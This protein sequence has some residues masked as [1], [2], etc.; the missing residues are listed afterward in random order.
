MLYQILKFPAKLSLHLYIRQLKINDKKWLCTKGTLLLA[1]NH[2]NSF[3]VAIIYCSLFN[4]PVY[5]LARG[6]VFKN[7]FAHTLLKSL[8]M[9]PVYRTSEGV[10]NLEHNYSTFAACKEIFKQ[11]GIVLIFSEGKCVNEWH[12]RPLKK[13]T[14]RL[15]LSSWDDGIPLKVLP[16]GINYQQFHCYDKEV[17]LFFGTIIS[18]EDVDHSNGFGRSAL[19]FNN[20][21]QKELQP[22]V[23]EINASDIEKR[24]SIFNCNLPKWKKA[25]L[26]LPAALGW[27][28]HALLYLPA[29]KTAQKLGKNNGHYDSILIAFLMLGYPVYVLLVTALV[30]ILSGSVFS[31]WML[32]VMP[33]CA[34]SYL[35]VKKR[36]YQK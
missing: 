15:A 7:K 6:D 30:F 27:L 9:L 21:L 13:G 35:Q 2:P 11:N 4:R 18:K 1:C 8:N 14:A 28:L 10:E 33:F 5:S 29:L 12:L 19:S 36:T 32:L 20:L 25:V 17:H 24:K 26:A 22:L 34:W 23:Y 16:T 3:L 31:L